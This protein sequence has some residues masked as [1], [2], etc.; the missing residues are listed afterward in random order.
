MT[1]QIDTAGILATW[2]QTPAQSLDPEST[3]QI[4]QYNNPLVPGSFGI[5]SEISKSFPP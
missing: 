4:K 3:D 1:T 2:E 5:L